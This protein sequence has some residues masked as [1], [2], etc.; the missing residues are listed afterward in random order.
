MPGVDRP[1]VCQPAAAAPPRHDNCVVQETKPG[2]QLDG[3]HR[4]ELVPQKG[5][6]TV[7][8]RKERQRN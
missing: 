4:Q 1:D 5:L 3:G 7:W 8:N 2:Q 6:R